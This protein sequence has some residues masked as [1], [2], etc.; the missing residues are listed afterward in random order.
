MAHIPIPDLQWAIEHLDL[1]PGAF[2]KGP[3]KRLGKG[4]IVHSP[5]PKCGGHDRFSCHGGVCVCNKCGYAFNIAKYIKNKGATT[6]VPIVSENELRELAEKR[7]REIAEKVKRVRLFLNSGVIDRLHAQFLACEK[8]QR[9]AREH[10]GFTVELAKKYKLGYD[11]NFACQAWGKKAGENHKYSTPAIVFP[12]FHNGTVIAAT[13]R[14]MEHVEECDKYRPWRKMGRAVVFPIVAGN[15]TL[16]ILE[17]AAK[18]IAVFE[19]LQ[20]KV[21][22]IAVS[23]VNQ[24]SG[25]KGESTIKFIKANYKAVRVLFD[26]DDNP[27]VVKAAQKTAVRVGGVALNAIGKPDDA[28]R[29]GKISP[30]WLLNY[31]LTTKGET[32]DEQ[33]QAGRTR[34]SSLSPRD[35]QVQEF[36]YR[37][38]KACHPVPAG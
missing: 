26:E 31:I 4:I 18:A 37:P 5:C 3:D 7:E 10:W 28:L 38:A 25:D 35:E 12:H 22:I 11:P 20:G 36:S 8:A 21:D 2:S 29:E 23:G 24:L 9:F 16:L 14:L 19:A 15:D 1:P 30:E 32:N 34:G 33:S 6:T 17:G 27:Q 13:A